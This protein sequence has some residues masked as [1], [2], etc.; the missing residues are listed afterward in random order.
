VTE[1]DANDV[2]QLLQESLLEVFTAESGEIDRGRK[3][4]GMGLS[5]QIKALVKV[6]TAEST[7]RQTGNMFSRNDI[8][9][10]CVKLKLERDVDSLIDVMRTECYLLLKGPRLYQLL[11]V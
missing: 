6:L 11:T 8:Q 9:E 5:K 10:V 4:G 7:K 1:D 2:V 3:G